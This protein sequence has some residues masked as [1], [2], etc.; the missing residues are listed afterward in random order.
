[1]FF[2]DDDTLPIGG[3]NSFFNCEASVIRETMSAHLESTGAAIKEVF[4]DY[5][6]DFD[7]K[8]NTFH[9]NSGT[10]RLNVSGDIDKLLRQC[11][12]KF[13]MS[14]KVLNV[15]KDNL[16]KYKKSVAVGRAWLLEQYFYGVF[17]HMLDGLEYQTSK[18]VRLIMASH[19]NADLETDIISFKKLPAIIHYLPKD[20]SPLYTIYTRS[21]DK[22]YEN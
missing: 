3:F 14:D 1:M 4:E 5:V 10:L 17:F 20:K 22:Y 2:V 9:I 19:N 15:I 18:Q 6:P 8:R 13:F 12:Y 11:V 21:I 7:E 16:T